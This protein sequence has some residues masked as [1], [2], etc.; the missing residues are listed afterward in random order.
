MYSHEKYVD[1][2]VYDRRNRKFATRMLCRTAR[3]GCWFKEISNNTSCATNLTKFVSN[4]S[5]R[6]QE[7]E[8]V[9]STKL[10]TN[11]LNGTVASMCI[12]FV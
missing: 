7:I 4:S 2:L 5:M 1:L 8:H 9:W 10:Q 3:L 11:R 6:E 12:F